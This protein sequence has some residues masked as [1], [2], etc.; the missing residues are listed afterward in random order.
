MPY[1]KIMSIGEDLEQVITDFRKASSATENI[2]VDY[3]LDS[4]FP[5]SFGKL[6]GKPSPTGSFQLSVN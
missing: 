1:M 5:Q 3:V 4:L 6:K 2:R